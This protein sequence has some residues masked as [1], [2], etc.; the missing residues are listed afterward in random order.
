M[1]VADS[2]STPLV[3]ERDATRVKNSFRGESK[4]DKMQPREVLGDHR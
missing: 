3:R 2:R 1:G 4:R